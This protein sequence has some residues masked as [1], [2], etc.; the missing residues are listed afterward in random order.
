MPSSKR[1]SSGCLSSRSPR[2]ADAATACLNAKGDPLVLCHALTSPPGLPRR[3]EPSVQELSARA[4][5]R[6]DLAWRAIQCLL[7]YWMARS[8]FAA[9]LRVSK[10]PRFLHLPVP[11]SFFSEYSRYLPEGSFRISAI[12]LLPGESSPKLASVVPSTTARVLGSR[13]RSLMAS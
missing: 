5:S 3:R 2:N 11:G 8:C 12:L 10:V 13:R 1:H 7:K 9:A 4:R 6:N